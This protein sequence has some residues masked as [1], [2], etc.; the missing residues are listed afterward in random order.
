VEML[1]PIT[2][3]R[4]GMINDASNQSGGI[5]PYPLHA[6]KVPTM[7]VS[8]EDDLY[9]TASIARQA[10]SRIPSSRLLIVRNGGHF[11]LGH[12]ADVWPAVADFL[13]SNQ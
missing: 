10:A 7:L 9:G 2:E 3:R 4:R 12:D 5:A 1:L 13:R 6:L 8:A 11:L